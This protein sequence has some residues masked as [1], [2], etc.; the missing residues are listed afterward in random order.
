MLQSLSRRHHGKD[1]AGGFYSPIVFPLRKRVLIYQK[2]GMDYL[3]AHL[4]PK[5]WLDTFII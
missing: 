3:R 4:M 2:Q 5:S 1:G